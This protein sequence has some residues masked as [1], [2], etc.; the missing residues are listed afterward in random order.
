MNDLYTLYKDQAYVINIYTREAHPIND[1][2]MDY[3][4]SPDGNPIEQP[5]TYEERVGMAAKT[6]E[7]ADLLLP[8]L[9]D[10]IDDPVYCSYGRLPNNAFLIGLD[11]K[12]V[13]FQQWSVPAE[14]EEALLD[15]FEEM[16]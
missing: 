1:R 7:E 6:I 8:V 11:G 14:M 5:V 13:A 12:I 10:A 9:V 4:T 3:S 16:P 15:Y 2:P